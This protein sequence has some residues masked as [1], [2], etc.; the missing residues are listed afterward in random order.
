MYTWGF[1]F[2]YCS[3]TLVIICIFYFVFLVDVQWYLI[4]ILIC[5][6]LMADNIEHLPLCL[7]AICVP[8]E[9]CSFRF[10]AHFKNY[11]VVLLFFL[12]FI[13]TFYLFI[14]RERGR[15]RGREKHRCSRETLMGCLSH[16]PNWGPGPWPRH[17][18]WLGIWPTIFWFMGQHFNQLSN[19]SQGNWVVFY[20]WVV[21]VLY[22]FW[23][24]VPFQIHNLQIFSSVPW[25]VFHF[26]DMICST[27][28][29]NIDVVQFSCSLNACA[30]DVMCKKPL[31]NQDHEELLLYFF[32]VVLY[33]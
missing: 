7:L 5:I 10:F 25:L 24:S 14:F 31:P 30:F 6:S 12:I 16:N 9:K 19:A 4:V 23:V 29:V 13:L 3:L 8:L 21:W 2:L 1:Q 11:V 17:G 18:P 28:V 22:I 26:L 20:Y 27:K 15:R 33:F 32:L